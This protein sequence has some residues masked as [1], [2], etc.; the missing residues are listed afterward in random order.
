M[1]EEL[2]R[3]VNA[4]A[5]GDTNAI[6]KLYSLTLKSSFYLAFRLCGNVEEAL[7][8]TRIEPVSVAYDGRY[9]ACFTEQQFFCLFHCLM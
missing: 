8:I 7:E 3:Y 9:A 5:A 2:V 4:A 1:N 6:A